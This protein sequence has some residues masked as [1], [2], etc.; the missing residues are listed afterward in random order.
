MRTVQSTL[1]ATALAALGAVAAAGPVARTQPGAIGT[2]GFIGEILCRFGVFCA[3]TARPGGCDEWGCGTNSP[4]VDGAAIQPSAVS[5]A[6]TNH[7]PAGANSLIRDILCR[8]GVFCASTAR[9]GGCDEFGCGTNSPVVDGAAIENDRRSTSVPAKSFHELHL[10]G[11]PNAAGFAIVGARKGGIPYTLETAPSGIV[12]RPKAGADRLLEGAALVDLVVDLRDSADWLYTLRIAATDTTPFW[13]HPQEP[14]R[15]FALTY[16]PANQSA[17]QPLCRTGVN[18]AI[19]FAGDRYNSEDKTVVATGAA[20]A[21]WVN[22]AC[23][24][25]ALAK[26]YL[27]RHTDASQ[28]VTTTR[29]ERQA[30]LKM[31]TADGCGDGRSSTVQGQPLLWADAKGIMTFA[32]APASIE[33]IWNDT[34]AVCLDVARRPELATAMA[35]RCV[36]PSCGGATT[37]AGRGHVISG[38]PR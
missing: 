15:T 1:I 9:P 8:F 5:P 19:L 29:G 17:V 38:N 4:V 36:R 12:A 18:K 3:S 33:A 28:I 24:G 21:G 26:L 23:A 35:A 25:T 13:A 27:T 22:I 31:F 2:T 16:T 32:S 37:A 6:A 7:R 11:I 14:T 34:G 30:M 20:T 10:G